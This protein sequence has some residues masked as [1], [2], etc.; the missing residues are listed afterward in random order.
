[1][2][3]VNLIYLV[4]I[5]VIDVKIACTIPPFELYFNVSSSNRSVLVIQCLIYNVLHAFL[6]TRTIHQATAQHHVL[7]IGSPHRTHYTSLAVFSQKY[8]SFL[9]FDKVQRFLTVVCQFPC[10]GT[11]R[12]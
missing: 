5:V 3:I 8:S 4:N 6:K 7:A 9:V 2:L 1:M 12:H 11:G 10:V